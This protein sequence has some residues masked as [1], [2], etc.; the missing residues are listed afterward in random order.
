[1]VSNRTNTNTYTE[2]VGEVEQRL[3]NALTAAF[4]PDL[5]REA[6]AEA[7]AYG[8]EHWERVGSMANAA[9]YLFRVG[10]TAGR[11]LGR[12]RPVVLPVPPA[13]REPWIEPGL[14]DALA[15]LSE[16]QRTVIGLRHGHQWSLSEVAE[17]LGL[18]KST[19]ANHER[20]GL[21]KLRRKLGVKDE[22]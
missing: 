17:L 19:V 5:G 9:G 11:R 15:A 14:P 4:G 8:W 7:L 20:R 13:H 1:M 6:T 22:H 12:R 10:Q 21:Q 18:S 3:R 2:F 16:L